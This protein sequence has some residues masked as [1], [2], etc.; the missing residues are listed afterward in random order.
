MTEFTCGNNKYRSQKIDAR[1][2][3]HI[4]RRLA[5]CLGGL[6]PALMKVG[7]KQA[8]A[9]AALDASKVM[10]TDVADILPKLADAMAA[11]D[12][13]TADYVLFGLLGAA[14]REQASGLGWAPV[15]N[16]R[17]LMFQDITMA[18]MLTIAGR[19][20]AANL[21]DFFVVLN[22]ISSQLGQVA[23]GQ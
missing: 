23:K 7:A 17:S 16:G 1:A 10:E 9:G 12:D 18:Q 2:Q 6:A 14:T 8:A 21:G 19:V 11:M 22:S 13:E 15:C 5:P 4:V 3:F 20:L